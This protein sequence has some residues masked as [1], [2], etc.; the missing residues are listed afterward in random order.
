MKVGDV[1]YYM[2]E[3]K[4]IGINKTDS[5]TK[6]VSHSK[7][8]TMLTKQLIEIIS[9]LLRG[10][11]S[12]EKVEM[13]HCHPLNRFK[14]TVR[15]TMYPALRVFFK[16]VRMVWGGLDWSVPC[17][18]NES[19][20]TAGT[21]FYSESPQ[22]FTDLGSQSVGVRR[23]PRDSYFQAPQC[24]S[25]LIAVLTPAAPAS[26]PL[27]KIMPWSKENNLSYLWS[28]LF[29]LIVLINIKLRNIV[30]IKYIKLW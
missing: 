12:S 3:K 15:K 25:L 8:Q 21:E 30:K 6:A 17:S 5:N 14:G 16:K 28:P 11:W 19:A 1:E 22:H 26:P 23:G 10:S 2:V 24:A 18:D 9:P 4:K 13:T 7:L 29:Y 27:Q 20:N